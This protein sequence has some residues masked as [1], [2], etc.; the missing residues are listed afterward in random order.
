MGLAEEQKARIKDTRFAVS[1][2]IIEEP[3][4]CYDVDQKEKRALNVVSGGFAGM[5]VSRT[6][7]LQRKIL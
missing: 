4:I 2:S 1:H 3:G 5:G 7:G 6:A